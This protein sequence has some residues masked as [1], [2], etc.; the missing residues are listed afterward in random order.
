MGA[1][2]PLRG[3]ESQVVERMEAS[4]SREHCWGTPVSFCA[5][6]RSR[7]ITSTALGDSLGPGTL[8]HPP[9]VRDLHAKLGGL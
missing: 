2:A 7:D 9:P 4:T 6:P 3:S 8:P 1:G 5:R